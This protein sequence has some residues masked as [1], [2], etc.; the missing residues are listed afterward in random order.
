MGKVYT[1]EEAKA[2]GI[3]NETCHENDLMETAYQMTKNVLAK[4]AYDRDALMNMKKQMFEH[5]TEKHMNQL[6]EHEKDI[7]SKL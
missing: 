1:A 3:V 7:Q 4:G 2:V 6:A 5:I